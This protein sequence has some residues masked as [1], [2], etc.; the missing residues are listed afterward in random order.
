MGCKKGHLTEQER[1]IIQALRKEK[2]SNNAISKRIGRDRRTVD[3]EIERNLTSHG[4]QPRKAR[5]RYWR[6]H[7]KAQYKKVDAKMLAYIK[8]RLLKEHSPE[9]ISNSMEKDFGSKISTRRIYDLVWENKKYGGELYKKLRIKNGKKRRKKRGSNA[10]R[11]QIPHRVDIDERPEIAN[12]RGR[13]GDWEADLVLGKKSTGGALVTLLERKSRLLLIGHVRRK[14]T[15]E[16]NAEIK[17]LLRPYRHVVETITYDNGAEFKKHFKI[18]KYL[19]CESYFAKPYHAWERGANENANGLI[20]QYI[21]KGADMQQV[22][23]RELRFIMGRINNRPRKVLDYTTANEVW[24][25][26]A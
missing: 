13:F 19:K 22:T 7:R 5:Q 11:Q 9:Q 21:P 4:Y 20:R 1:I 3:R 14:T 6:L 26:V 16:V 25:S 17:R 24:L 12:T 8:K 2:F 23:R 15:K 18:N 10:Y